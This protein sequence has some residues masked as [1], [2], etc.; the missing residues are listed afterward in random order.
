MNY[1]NEQAKEIETIKER[2]I[3][4]RL[5]DA[6]CERITTKGGRYGLTVGNILEN[7][8]GDL[9]SGTY[10][11]GSD[12]RRMAEEW[13]ERCWF[14]ICPEETLLK[15]LLEWDY[16]VEGF[17][18]A[19][20]EL[21][22]YEANPQEFSDDLAKANGKMLWF[23]EEYHNCIDEFIDNK[24]N[25]DIEKEIKLCKVWLDNFKKLKGNS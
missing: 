19:Y 14:S 25:I 3:T 7:F 16:D 13:F 20:D 15:H 23:E 9:V 21:R 24:G 18:D 5:S 10:S 2:T 17:I 11:N 6:D 22:Y 1:D 4:I 8:I 12:E